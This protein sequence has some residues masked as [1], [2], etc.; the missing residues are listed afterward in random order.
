M[1]AVLVAGTQGACVVTSSSDRT[2]VRSLRALLAFLDF[3]LD[4]LGFGQGLE[5]AALDF[6]EMREQVLAAAV[7]GNEAEAKVLLNLHQEP[8]KRSYVEIYEAE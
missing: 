8:E 7:L 1:A 4:A 5:T 3:E 2:D 6:A